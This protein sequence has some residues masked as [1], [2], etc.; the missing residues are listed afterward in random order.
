MRIA[1]VLPYLGKPAGWR[2]HSIAF[3]NAMRRHVQPVLFVSQADYE[4]ACAL[5]P[6]DPIYPLPTTQ[7]AALSSVQNL[8]TLLACYRV[9]HQERYPEVDLVHS[10]EAYPTGLVGAWLARKLHQPHAITTHGTY[11]VVWNERRLD[12]LV[13]EQVLKRTQLICPVSHG[14]ANLMRTYF[15]H[16]MQHA[17]LKPILNGNNYTQSVSQK[18]AFDHVFP[19]HPIL[20]S[21]GDVKPRKGQHLSL[22]AFARVKKE[23][24][25]ARYLIAGQYRHNPYY[26]KL[27]ELINSYDLPEVRFLGVVSDEDLRRFYRQASLFVL[28]PEQNGL[29]FEGF[30]LVYLEAGA[31]GLPVVATRSGGVPDA[32]KDEVTGLLAEPG[33]VDGIAE[34]ILRLLKD[35][36]LAQRM[37]RAN[38]QWAE[39]LTWERCAKEQYQAYQE[40]F[41]G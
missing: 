5:F 3:I 38:R 37:G 11:G 24:P 34:A 19:T 32:V 14:T 1:Y 41:A 28:T 12:R 8:K 29:H 2:N 18:E 20:L 15:G 36:E 35:P 13:Y 6:G 39:T 25:A 26:L 33:D 31:Y 30:G 9:I 16:A 4:A 27:Q 21:V 10:L 17:R 22:Q 7:Q 40:L 23:F